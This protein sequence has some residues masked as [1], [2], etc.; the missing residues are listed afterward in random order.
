MK[1][2]C[3]PG[4]NGLQGFIVTLI[5]KKYKKTS[6]KHPQNSKKDLTKKSFD[7]NMKNALLWIGMLMPFF[8]I[9]HIN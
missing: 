2:P 8:T 9:V 7:D 1:F 5:I 6:K 4:K 3:K